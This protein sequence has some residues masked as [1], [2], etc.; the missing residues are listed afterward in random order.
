MRWEFGGKFLPQPEWWEKIIDHFTSVTSPL[1]RKNTSNGLQSPRSRFF[2]SRNKT[3]G[4]KTGCIDCKK[5]W[6][7]NLVL[8]SK[9]PVKGRQTTISDKIGCDTLPER[10]FLTFY[11][12]K[13]VKVK[14]FPPIPSMQCS[15]TVR[16]TCRKQKTPQLWMEGRGR[17]E[18]GWSYPVWVQCLNNF[19][20]DC[21]V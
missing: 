12:I 15:A 7:H 21:R 9:R 18:G 1:E 2:G 17:V 3:W 11:Q 19:V 8:P 10:G 13:R 16:A 14:L 6:S 5:G 20:L 4:M